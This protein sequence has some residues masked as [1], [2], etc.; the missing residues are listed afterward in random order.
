MAFF[1]DVTYC[2]VRVFRVCFMDIPIRLA[3]DISPALKG[4]FLGAVRRAVPALATLV[5]AVFFAHVVRPVS[6]AYLFGAF[7]E[8]GQPKA[9]PGL[10][11]NEG[12]SAETGIASWYGSQR[13]G[14]QY[15]RT[16]NMEIMDP[17]G[18]TCAHRTLPFGTI[19]EVLNL[20]NGRAVLLRVNDRGP[21]V[22]GRI[23][24]LS[25]RGAAQIGIL[26]RGLAPVRVREVKNMLTGNH[27]ARALRGGGSA[28]PEIT[29]MPERP[30]PSAQSGRG[31]ARVVGLSCGHA[32]PSFPDPVACRPES[33]EGMLLSRRI[34]M[35]GPFGLSLTRGA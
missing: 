6:G 8:A 29:A 1:G 18:F 2:P 5:A 26:G 20:A 3:C 14:F 9:A 27:A 28:K 15:K 19:V 35:A 11:Q 4:G 17:D 24:D 13:D 30:A 33:G 22:A 7:A 16:A 32:L 25:M 34:R 31:L 21:F 10:H 23:V 12:L